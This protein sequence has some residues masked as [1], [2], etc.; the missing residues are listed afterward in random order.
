MVTAG[1]KMN[2]LGIRVEDDGRGFDP[3]TILNSENNK[4]GL[5]SLRERFEFFEGS[6]MIDSRKGG[7]TRIEIAIPIKDKQ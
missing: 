7:G 3:H 1:M 6:F 2:M 4:M 5:F